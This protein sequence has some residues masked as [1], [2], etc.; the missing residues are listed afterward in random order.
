[1]NDTDVFHRDFDDG[2]RVLAWLRGSPSDPV[3]VVA[4]F[5]DWGTD[6]SQPNAEYRVPNWPATP[7]GK[8]WFEVTT[9]QPVP[10]AWIGRWGLTPWDAKVYVLR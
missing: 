3:V 8:T 2:K 1:V 9:N 4:N 7:P 6:L 10:D 5:S